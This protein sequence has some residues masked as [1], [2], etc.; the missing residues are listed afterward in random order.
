MPVKGNWAHD[1][2]DWAISE[3]IT[4]GTSA[5]TFDPED[6][7]TRAQVVTFLY[8]NVLKESSQ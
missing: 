6:T 5:T 2:I 4:N 1:S 8:R 7:C 3:G